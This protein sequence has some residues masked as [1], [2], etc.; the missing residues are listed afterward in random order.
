MIDGLFQPWHLII[1][2]VIILIIFGP[3]KLPDLGSALGKGIKEFR[4]GL[5]EVTDE[6]EDDPNKSATTTTTAATV[7]PEVTTPH[8]SQPINP[9]VAPTQATQPNAPVVTATEPS[10]NGVGTQTVA[11]PTPTPAAPTAARVCVAC[12]HTLSPEVR[13]C[14]NCGTAAQS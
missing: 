12:G 7:T 3:G 1:I 10:A 5:K 13:F 8:V 6:L 4:G 11:A 2:L 14:P 9:P